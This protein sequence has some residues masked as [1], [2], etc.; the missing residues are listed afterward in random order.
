MGKT[1]TCVDV[2]HK[3]R[4]RPKLK[5]QRKAL[6]ETAYNPNGA[7][8]SILA[9]PTTPIT[10]RPREGMVPH[11]GQFSVTAATTTTRESSYR[12]H[13]NGYV[14]EAQPVYGPITARPAPI[15][16]AS[17]PPASNAIY[18]HHRAGGHLSEHESHSFHPAAVTARPTSPPPAYSGRAPAQLDSLFDTTA[19]PP[20]GGNAYHGYAQAASTYSPSYFAVS[21]SSS[22]ALLSPSALSSSSSVRHRPY[23]APSS[24]SAAPLP[25]G[26]IR[27]PPLKL[28][29]PRATPLPPITLERIQA[30]PSPCTLPVSERSPRALPL[31]YMANEAVV[32]LAM[33]YTCLRTTGNCEQV[34]G[35]S[36]A[37]VLERPLTEFLYTDDVQRFLRL[38]Q[39]LLDQL[40]LSGPAA[41]AAPLHHTPA[42]LQ[43]R[44]LAVPPTPVTA[45]HIADL[46]QPASPTA[47]DSCASDAVPYFGSS[48]HSA[49]RPASMVVTPTS[50]TSSE[51]TLVGDQAAGGGYFSPQAPTAGC[52][53]IKSTTAQL[54]AASLH[55]PDF[56]RRPLPSL[57]VMAKRSFSVQDRMYF[58]HPVSGYT[59]FNVRLHLGGGLGAERNR[60]ET[61]HQLYLVCHI[62]PFE[63]DSLL[64]PKQA[65]TYDPLKALAGAPVSHSLNHLV[66]TT[67]VMNQTHSHHT[68]VRQMA[69]LN[70][71]SAASPHTGP[72]EPPPRDASGPSYLSAHHTDQHLLSPS[73][74]NVAAPVESARS[75]AAASTAP[76]WSAY[77]RSS[78]APIPATEDAIDGP[79]LPLRSPRT[80]AAWSPNDTTPA[81]H[82]HHHPVPAPPLTSPHSP[83]YRT[84]PMTVD[85]TRPPTG[86]LPYIAPATTSAAPVQFRPLPSLA[87]PPDRGRLETAAPT[88]A[89]LLNHP[90]HLPSSS[91][92]SAY[93]YGSLMNYRDHSAI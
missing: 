38:R 50:L 59:L 11:L 41:F 87:P 49:P 26:G 85:T 35:L 40:V 27:L 57:M 83:A 69:Q 64:E 7:T 44:A 34:L 43:S 60:S 63:F 19:R 67:S 54:N 30:P 76:F 2:Q 71:G 91:A 47:G 72:R 10:P 14:P 55:T 93:R 88:V 62:S 18:Y 13:S 9:A 56:Y 21:T 28:H 82:H 22:P 5:D 37:E 31:S 92:G 25:S 79:L 75:A 29:L 23:P 4:G 58:R 84:V 24:L 89:F 8:T 74:R 33:D 73:P 39:Q 68:A 61:Y 3:K 53:G 70:M 17:T 6:A 90:A 12:H 15:A 65:G 86:K 46:L 1:A 52:A 32:L 20:A 77:A 78:G 42:A 45:P 81:H 36:E 80:T 51:T 66:H 16:P 48:A